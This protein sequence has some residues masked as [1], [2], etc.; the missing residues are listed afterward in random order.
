MGFSRLPAAPPRVET[1]TMPAGLFPF[2]TTL[3]STRA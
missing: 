1:T 2:A 3:P